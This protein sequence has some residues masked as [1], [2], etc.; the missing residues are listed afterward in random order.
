[1]SIHTVNDD[2]H[3]MAASLDIIHRHNVTLSFGSDFEEYRA[4]LKEGRPDH[5]L[6]APFDPEIHDL[7]ESNALW[8]VGRDEDGTVMH[9]QALRMI[10]LGFQPLGEY[11]R[12]DFRDFPPSGLDIDYN[13]SRYRAGPGA[14]RITGN[15]CYH[16]E[17]W[18]GG[19]PG[20][21]RGSG[22][23]CVLGRFA[24]LVAMQRWSPDH[25]FGFMPKPVAFKGFAERQGYMHAE[26]GSLR[27]FIR[28]QD[29]P[30]EG[31]MVYMSNEDVR[32][33]L[34]MPLR[35]LIPQAA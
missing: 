11:L 5:I 25:I 30:L 35:E 2:A 31:F 19:D 12:R 18:M 33:V 26:P 7:D 14:Q 10:N 16:G 34:D 20:K 9:C 13:R 27:W 8:I 6:G 24:F 1:M 29:N 17:V 3:F 21:Y 4:I 28:G 15:V 22:L 23:S 32:F